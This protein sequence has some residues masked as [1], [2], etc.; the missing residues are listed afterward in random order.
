MRFDP[1]PSTLAS[2]RGFHALLDSLLPS[3]F[4]QCTTPSDSRALLLLLTAVAETIERNNIMIKS[5]IGILAVTLACASVSFG[6]ER[7]WRSYDGVIGPRH[8]GFGPGGALEM[9]PGGFQ[10]FGPGGGQSIGPGGGQSIGPSGGLSIG[11]GGGQSIGPGGGRSIGPGGGAS[12][13]PGG[14]LSIGPCGGRSIA[15]GG[16][17]SMLP[18]ECN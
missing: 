16:G 11:P 17:L 8:Q 1:Y 2:L 10:S 18:G 13:G 15:P 3:I 4:G 9:G 6:E 7:G 12:I 5:M 14:G